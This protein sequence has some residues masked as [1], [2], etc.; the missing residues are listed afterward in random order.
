TKGGYHGIAN[1]PLLVGDV[2]VLA[3]G[4]GLDKNSGRLA[5]QNTEAM[6]AGHAS[7]VLCPS[8]KQTGVLIAWQTR[9]VCV[10][11]STGKTLWRRDKGGGTLY[12]DPMVSGDQIVTLRGRWGRALR[13][14]ATSVADTA[15][16]ELATGY[17]NANPVCWKDHLYV[18]LSSGAADDGSTSDSP[19]ESRCSL[20]CYET[21]TF[22]K[23]WTK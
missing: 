10:D 15:E 2:L 1:S 13:F 23:K 11:P 14:T 6:T 3:H 9:Q 20:T 7:P 8:G 4:I 19:D 21:N 16:H 5:W 18:V 12:L 22:K 17:G